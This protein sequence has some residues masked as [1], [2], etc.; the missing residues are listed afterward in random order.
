M[1][2]C[3][4]DAFSGVVQQIV[5]LRRLVD[6]VANGFEAA[7]PNGLDALKLPIQVVVLSCELGSS[8]RW[9]KRQ[10]IDTVRRSRLR[11]LGKGRQQIPGSRDTIADST[12]F[13]VARPARDQGDADAAFVELGFT[14]AKSARALEELAVDAAHPALIIAA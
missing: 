7:A 14:A 9:Q 4:V 2:G 6:T 8:E 5:E 3:N 10:A 11:Q 12:R 1:F 13:D